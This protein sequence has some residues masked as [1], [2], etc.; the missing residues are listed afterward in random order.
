VDAIV[1]MDRGARILGAG[2]RLRPRAIAEVAPGA[3]I[4]EYAGTVDRAACD[5]AGLL[6]Y[7]PAAASGGHVARTIGEILY[8]PVVELHTAGLRV[9]EVMAR[10]RAEGLGRTECEARA[11]ADG[12]GERVPASRG[13]SS[14]RGR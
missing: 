2:S 10:G 11:V 9:G 12:P 3:C 7:P 5:E 6:V 14:A 13:S 8:A 1:V 4:L